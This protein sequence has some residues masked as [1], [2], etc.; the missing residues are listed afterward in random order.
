M[1]DAI[2]PCVARYDEE[3]ES[4]D[5]DIREVEPLAQERGHGHESEYG[6]AMC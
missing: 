5:A 2:L 3:N 4:N 6:D 1:R